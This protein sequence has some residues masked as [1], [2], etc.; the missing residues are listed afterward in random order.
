MKAVLLVLVIAFACAQA[1]VGSFVEQD[2]ATF[3]RT[4][5]MK[6]LLEFG[7]QEVSNQAVKANALSAP[8]VHINKVNS[9]G[10]Q[11]VAGLN[12]RFNVDA[13]D[14]QGKIQNVTFIVFSQPWS[15]T[16]SLVS[17]TIN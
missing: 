15:N 14:A 8:L 6:N 13:V 10:T 9:V 3:F 7:Q 12:V 4:P 1:Q 5:E 2:V 11:V 16:R 17:Y